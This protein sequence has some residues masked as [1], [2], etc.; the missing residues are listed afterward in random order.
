MS[1]V[2]RVTLESDLQTHLASL[3]PA[4]QT[5]EERIR[6]L[7]KAFA[8]I[9]RW[10]GASD[11]T[12]AQHICD[13]SARASSE[14]KLAA[15]LHEAEEGALG[16]WLSPVKDMFRTLGIQNVID[17]MIVLPLRREIHEMMG[18]RWPVSAKIAAEIK[19]LDRRLAATEYRD[20]VDHRIYPS[21]P[22]AAEPYPEL[23]LPWSKV[24][25][26]ERF[27]ELAYSLCPALAC[28]GNEKCA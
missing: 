22:G 26:E 21:Y 7:A 13:M 12:V 25:A 24:R 5:A 17:E 4:H 20:T 9:Q 18:A 11:V 28:K 1:F 8:S 16:D 10:K 3:M 19:M 6:W 15:F 2:N 27:L 23:M 14:A